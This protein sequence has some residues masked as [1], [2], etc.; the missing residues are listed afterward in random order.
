MAVSVRE[1]RV[2]CRRCRRRE[3]KR[4]EGGK[5][6]IQKVQGGVDVK[7]A[8]RFPYEVE[9]GPNKH[10]E[11]V[12]RLAQQAQPIAYNKNVKM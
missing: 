6:R 11:N 2:E 8:V 1:V 7:W 10:I 4:V 3:D 9:S 12:L 5:G